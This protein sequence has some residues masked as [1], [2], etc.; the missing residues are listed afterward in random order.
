MFTFT[1]TFTTLRYIRRGTHRMCPFI[2]NACFESYIT[3]L[4]H[5]RSFSNSYWPSVCNL[6]QQPREL[7]SVSRVRVTACD[8]ALLVITVITHATVCRSFSRNLRHGLTSRRLETDCCWQLSSYQYSVSSY[9]ISACSNVVDHN[10]YAGY[11]EDYTLS[12][13]FQQRK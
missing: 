7:L 9:L 11:K 3:E 4:R 10:N 6:F 1:F 2:S 5:L 8:S 12:T 13:G